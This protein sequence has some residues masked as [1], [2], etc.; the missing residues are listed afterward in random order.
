MKLSEVVAYLNHLDQDDLQPDFDKILSHASGVLHSVTSKDLQIDNFS[1]DLDAD[2]NGIKKSVKQFEDTISLLRSKLQSIIQEQEPEYYAASQQLYEDE[3][4]WETN[5]YI[6]ERKLSIPSEE[7]N[8]ILNRIKLFT[9]WR[10]PGMIL[11]PG[12]EDFIE[13]LVP[14]DPLYLIDQHEELLAP[15]VVNF[16]EVYRRRLRQYVVDDRK[17]RV[18]F[19]LLPNG[20]FGFVFA[21]NYFNYKPLNLIFR[22]LDEL[23][24]KLR[25]GGRIIFTY[26]D[27]DFSQAVI[28]AERSFMCYTPG[29][30]IKSYAKQLGFE[31]EMQCCSPANAA[32]LELKK[33]GEIT[34]LRG[35]QSLAK[36]I[37]K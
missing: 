23:Y 10:I 37:P 31:I 22:Y 1:S 32:W 34:S 4:I 36:I 7:R 21:Y 30:H 9:D 27:C 25:P 6:L 35:G 8:H 20:Q 13:S 26:N 2:F 12:K 33:P 5:E 16:D 18:I 17:D 3:M 19:Q 14:L 24:T 29:R 28:L 11:R 15:S